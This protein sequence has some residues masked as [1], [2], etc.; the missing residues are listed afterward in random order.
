MFSFFPP[1]IKQQRLQLDEIIGELHQLAIEIKNEDL[2]RTVG[3]LRS[4]LNEPFMFVIV[5]EVKAGKSSFINAL[6]DTGREICKVAP[7]PM[8][9]TIQQIIW[10]ESE[11]VAIVNQHLRKIYQP[12]EILRE[13]S[14]VDTPGTNTIIAHHQEITEGFI[15]SSDLIVFVF[16]AK[17][18]YRQSAWD[19]FQ[20]I[21]ADWRKKIIFVL[22]QR[23]LLPDDDLAV[24]FKGVQDYA[25]Q[26][27]IESPIV[28]SVS[29]KQELEGDKN[30]SGFAPLR[31]YIAKN[32]T[33]GQAPKLKLHNNIDLAKNIGERIQ[34]GLNLRAEQ[35]NADKAFRKDVRETLDSQEKR[36][37]NHVDLLVENL[38]NSYDDVTGRTEQAL[39]EGIGF[40]SLTKRSISSIF[41]KNNSTKAWL[42]GLAKDL[43]TQLNEELFRKLN[44]GVTDISESIQQMAKVIDLKLRHSETILKNN[45]DIFGDIADRRANVLKDLQQEFSGFIH[46][47]E[48]YVEA[49][50][51]PH[52]MSVAPTLVQGGGMAVIGVILATVTQGAV[53]D[54]TGGIIT[55][56][57]LLFAGISIALKKGRIMRDFRAEIN[58]G[59]ERLKREVNDR[60]KGYTARLKKKLDDNF[61]DFDQMLELEEK[62]IAEL[63]HRNGQITDKLGKLN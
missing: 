15:P 1:D 28:F 58:K 52:E 43:E 63:N 30:G 13:I 46:R 49:A 18:P 36:S 23:D 7:Q 31:E 48:T 59:H 39:D 9:D 44:A 22:Q 27:G 55:A 42:D 3:E 57:G 29:A 50:N 4:R 26:K 19:F 6:L 56:V 40:F 35:L 41:N 16:E 8:T 38:L 47:T 33:G 20:F 32:I 21:H 5:G 25:K 51:L 45:H 24:N 11:S 37:G 2:A 34:Q 12:V 10:G 62:Q 61:F 54:I 53:M 17:N 14:I 60:L